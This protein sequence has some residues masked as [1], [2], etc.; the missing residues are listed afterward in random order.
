LDKETTMY[1]SAYHF[2]GD[3]AALARAHDEMTARFPLDSLPLDLC[4][5]TGDGIVVFDACPTAA[6][7][8]VFQQSPEFAAAL[9]E[10]GLP[11]PRIESVGEIWSTVGVS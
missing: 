2:T 7:A 5:K 3:S 8:V 10:A 6:D 9:A 1:L 11:T 4:V